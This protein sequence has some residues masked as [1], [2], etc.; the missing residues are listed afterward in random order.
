[1][2]TPSSFKEENPDVLFDLIEEHNFGIIFS[3]HEDQ[4]EATHLPFLVHRKKGTY[5]TLIA[6][7][8]KANKHWKKLDESK[9]VL[10]LFQGPHSYISPAWYENRA[11]VPTWNYATVHVFG[12]PK[13]IEDPVE[14]NKM[15]KKL[16]HFHEGQEN[17]D[18]KLNE[19]P[20]KEYNTDLKAIVGLEIE[21]SKM[22]GKFK[23]NQNKSDMDQK[24]VIAKMDDLGRK[25]ISEIMKRT[26]D[27]SK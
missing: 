3:Q 11:E 22:E 15:V 5:G 9:D 24:S 12:K 13:I 7:F 14:L 10:I 6:H 26:L 8:A 27:S 4:P 21:I 17:T 25:D 2:Y 19:V 16:T 18:W 1:M 20:K 23:F